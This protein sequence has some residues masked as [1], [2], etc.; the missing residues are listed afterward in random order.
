[1]AIVLDTTTA[2]GIGSGTSMS[3]SHTCNTNFLVVCIGLFRDGGTTSVTGI[4]YNGDALTKAVGVSAQE[5]G[6]NKYRRSE[7]WYKINPAQG[8]N[9]VSATISGSANTT[10][11]RSMSFSGVNISDALEDTGYDNANSQQTSGEFDATATKANSLFVDSLEADIGN[12]NNPSS[13][14]RTGFYELNDSG[15]SESSG[16]S[17]KTDVAI[18]A[19]TYTY[20][21]DGGSRYLCYSGAIFNPAPAGNRGYIIC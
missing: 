6:A 5:G 16:I 11:G 12:I 20:P 10:F 8:A 7:I 17:Y 13:P 2:D 15:D 1:M 21:T 9:T 14:A 18:G 4:T 3:W 19:A